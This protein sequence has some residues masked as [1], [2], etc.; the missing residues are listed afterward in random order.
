MASLSEIVRWRS[1][2][3]EKY[4]EGSVGRFERQERKGEGI[5]PHWAL[6]RLPEESRRGCCEKEMDI[7]LDEAGRMSQEDEGELEKVDVYEVVE[8]RE[9][10]R[11]MATE[12]YAGDGC[13]T[14]GRLM[15]ETGDVKK[16]MLVVLV[17]CVCVAM[18]F[19]VCSGSSRRLG[20]S[21]Y[22]CEG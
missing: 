18:E 15:D 13:G 10:E 19:F 8:S 5:Q 16:G 21:W 11:H 7:E 12:A 20:S 1:S 6:E 3:S 2:S 9:S 17:V 4:D 22:L 14:A